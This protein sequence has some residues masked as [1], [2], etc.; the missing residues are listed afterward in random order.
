MRPVDDCAG[1]RGRRLGFAS[2][3]AALRY[4]D[5]GAR[6]LVHGLKDGGLRALAAPAA[7]LM[8][9]VID[10][11]DADLL[12][13]VPP[14]PLRQALRG[15]HAP[16]LLAEQLSGRWG[17]PASR[18]LDGPLW[19]RPQ[20]GLARDGRRRNVRGAFTARAAV[21]GR[22]VLVDDVLTTGATLSAAARALRSAGAGEV[23]AVTLA[24]AD[25][26]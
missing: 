18:L 3:A 26:R 10:R 11:P 22:I 2:A 24:R 17:L 4:D 20:R 21:S 13:W 12:T 23:R 1:C 14:D 15:Y 8:A 19:R 16:R 6:A 5:A 9:L 25:D 7:G